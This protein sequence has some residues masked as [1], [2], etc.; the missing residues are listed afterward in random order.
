[1]SELREL[2]KLWDGARAAGAEFVLVTVVRVEGSSY[3]KPGARMLITRDGRRC[4]MVSGGCLEGEVIRKAWWLT[5]AGPSLQ[6]YET[7]FDEDNPSPRNLGCGGIV[8]LLLERANS[9][10][11]ALRAIRE[12]TEGRFDVSLITVTRSDDPEIAVGAHL[13]LRDN[14]E[15]LR[16]NIP[17]HRGS[18]EWNQLLAIASQTIKQRRSDYVTIRSGS[19]SLELFAEYVAP[20]PALFVFG[21]GDDAIPVAGFAHMMGWHVTVADARAHL[22]TR[23]RFPSADAT[24]GL[25]TAVKV[26]PARAESFDLSELQLGPDSSAV[27]MT[28]SY[29]QDRALLRQLLPRDLCYLGILGPRLRTGRLVGEIADEVGL[30]RAECLG[31]LHSPVGLD[32]GAG[33][34]VVIALS[35]AAEI[36]AAI[37]AR[38]SAGHLQ[39]VS[40]IIPFEKLRG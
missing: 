3:R 21:A 4:G 34:P 20:P 28:H 13:A 31:K 9:A 37:H 40:A 38:S 1:M 29:I 10:S 22:A 35:I 12:G 5:E 18:A 15:L 39:G 14:G 27:I 32:L 11:L 25:K 8:Y 30:S 19:H 7:F 36:Q 23:E 17:F 24:V 26:M 33:S 2:L 16:N 6:R